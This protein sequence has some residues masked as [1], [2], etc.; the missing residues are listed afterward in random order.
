MKKIGGG[1]LGL[2]MSFAPLSALAADQPA[3]GLGLKAFSI[4]LFFILIL[5]VFAWALKRYGPVARVKRSMGLDILGQMPLSTKATL[6]LV[7]VGNSLLLLGVTHNH[8]SLI[9]ELG[10]TSFE[11][12][13]GVSLKH[14]Q[15]LS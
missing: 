6:A 3:V 8:V 11:K 1:L 7:R 4:V 9:K 15:E 2:S 10:E 14:H 5:G 12:A 13:V